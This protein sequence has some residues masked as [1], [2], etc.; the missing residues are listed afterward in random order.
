MQSF[1]ALVDVQVFANAVVLMQLSSPQ[2]LTFLSVCV[3]DRGLA[4]LVTSIE[5]GARGA[6]ADVLW[7]CHCGAAKSAT[8]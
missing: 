5:H 8:M 7:R 4:Q 2:G 6:A 1:K 3:P